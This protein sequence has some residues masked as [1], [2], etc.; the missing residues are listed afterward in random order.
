M[1]EYLEAQGTEIPKGF[2]KEEYNDKNY[3]EQ[4]K[5]YSPSDVT[6]DDSAVQQSNVQ[7]QNKV[8]QAP[9]MPQQASSVVLQNVVQQPAVVP[10]QS[11]NS[12]TSDIIFE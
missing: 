5:D 12:V 7:A 2:I 11:T 9:V 1:I 10:Q 4:M 8:E 3:K 6:A